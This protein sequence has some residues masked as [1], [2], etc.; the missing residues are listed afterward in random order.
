MTEKEIA[1]ADQILRHIGDTYDNANPYEEVAQDVRIY[2]EFLEAVEIRQRLEIHAKSIKFPEL[3]KHI[4][5][6]GKRQPVP[7]K[8]A[9]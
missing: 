6:M 3:A 9:D 1:I 5:Q 2:K 7:R 8:G 4:P